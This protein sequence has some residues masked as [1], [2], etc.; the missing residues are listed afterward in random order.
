[1]RE[2]VKSF[3]IE[4]LF[5]LGDTMLEFEPGVNILTGHNGSFKTTILQILANVLRREF[6]RF[7]FLDFKSIRVSLEQGTGITLTRFQDRD[8]ITGVTDYLIQVEWGDF[9]EVLSTSE[10]ESSE[11]SLSISRDRNLSHKVDDV[12]SVLPTTYLPAFRST[13]EAFRT[14]DQDL[15]ASEITDKIRYWRTPFVP[16]VGYPALTE[17]EKTLKSSQISPVETDS[18]IRGVNNFLEKKQLVV[19][20][21]RLEPSLPPVRIKH[22]NGN[23]S[24]LGILS[25]GER[26][27]VILL[28]TAAIADHHQVLLIDEP[29]NSLHVA[30]Q[31]KLLDLMEDVGQ[32]SQVIA[33]THSPVIASRYPSQEIIVYQDH[34]GVSDEMPYDF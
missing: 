13:V 24:K 5:G 22:E 28:Y 29:E 7:A 27:I 1:M 11:P 34:Q 31:R 15:S 18:Y 14:L 25:S 6:D 3:R 12:D 30:W 9:F 4:G 17:I 8:D 33:C 10:I 23:F 21:D 19:D 26:E 2:F 20:L 16:Y 32:Y